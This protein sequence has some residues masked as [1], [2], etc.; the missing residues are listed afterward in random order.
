LERTNIA[1]LKVEK[2]CRHRYNGNEAITT[3]IDYDENGNVTSKKVGCRR[4]QRMI[5]V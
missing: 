1:S 5:M 3:Y 2:Q 4:L